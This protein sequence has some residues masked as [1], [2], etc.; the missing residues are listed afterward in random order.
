VFEDDGS[1][2]HCAAFESETERDQ[3][4]RTLTSAAAER[5][6][7]VPPAQF[8]EPASRRRGRPSHT[9]A[10]DAAVRALGRRLDRHKSIAERA[11]LVLHHMAQTCDDAALLPARSTVEIALRRRTRGKARG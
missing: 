4:L 10:I 9:Q 5:V 6:A 3:A 8:E 1:V 2:V 7:P 11:R